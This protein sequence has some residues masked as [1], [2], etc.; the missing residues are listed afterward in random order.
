VFK[1]LLEVSK[2]NDFTNQRKLHQ[3]ISQTKKT[4][5]KCYFQNQEFNNIDLHLPQGAKPL[6][7][8]LIALLFHL[9]LISNG[10]SS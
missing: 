1:N 8:E 7:D 10:N 9:N 5:N 3:R 2:T 4:K 6:K